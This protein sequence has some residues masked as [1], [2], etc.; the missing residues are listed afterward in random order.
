M[1]QRTERLFA[2][3]MRSHFLKA[4]MERPVRGGSSLVII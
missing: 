1:Q 4:A 2:D 3:D